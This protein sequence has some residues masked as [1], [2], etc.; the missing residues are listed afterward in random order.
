MLSVD[1]FAHGTFGDTFKYMQKWGLWFTYFTF[2]TG[3][4]ACTPPANEATVLL[5][6]YKN[7]PMQAWK[8][9]SVLYEMSLTLNIIITVIYWTIL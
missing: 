1:K 2:M 3:L 5:K 7:S 9:Y 4:F 8:W 6:S